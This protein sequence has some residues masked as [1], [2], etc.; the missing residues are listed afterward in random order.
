MAPPWS[1]RQRL[2]EPT[3]ALKDLPGCISLNSKP[4]DAVQIETPGGGGF[5]PAGAPAS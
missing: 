4:G 5:D 2:L 3:G 1:G